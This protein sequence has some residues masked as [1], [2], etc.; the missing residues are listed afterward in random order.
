[1]TPSADDWMNFASWLLD[2]SI[3]VTIPLYLAAWGAG[4]FRVFLRL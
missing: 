2:E 1:V 3:Q 4:V